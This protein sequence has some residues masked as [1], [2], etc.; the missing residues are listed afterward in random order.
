ML[1]DKLKNDDYFNSYIDT[2]NNSV[3]W[4]ENKLENG[5]VKENRILP[6]KDAANSD[7]MMIV[8]AKY[9]RGDDTNDLK[10]EF[11]KVFEEF[12]ALSKQ[13]V[14]HSYSTNLTFLSLAILLNTSK[15]DLETL[16]PLNLRQDSLMNFLI[17]GEMTNEIS[18]ENLQ[19]EDYKSLYEL[20]FMADKREQSEQLK[21][22]VND[23]WYKTN[24]EMGWYDSHKETKVNIYNGYWCFEAAAV[25]KLLN[26]P[27]DNL[28]D[29]Q[30]YPYD[31][32]H[33]EG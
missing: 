32:A 1:R 23:V 19:R 26:V 21:T 14:T 30:Y 7:R 33:F 2:K 11:S 22:F 31:L 8:I 27:D 16:K 4:F 3:Q 13:G 18:K 24:D 5:E 17:N 10:N 6:V 28:K 12:I 29:S 20:I 15:S 9:S 25:A